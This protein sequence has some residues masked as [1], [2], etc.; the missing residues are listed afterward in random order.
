M[1]AWHHADVVAHSLFFEL[2]I[3][4]FKNRFKNRVEIIDNLILFHNYVIQNLNKPYIF[5]Q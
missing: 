4:S 5:K 2:K 1:N 3:E